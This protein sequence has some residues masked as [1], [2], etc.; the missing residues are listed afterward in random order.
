MIGVGVGG[1]RLLVVGVGGWLTGIGV[2]VV[3]AA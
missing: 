3:W 1:G 2:S